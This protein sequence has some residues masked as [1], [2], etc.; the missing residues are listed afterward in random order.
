MNI[1][2]KTLYSDSENLFLTKASF[3]Q[4]KVQ[5]KCYSNVAKFK[6]Y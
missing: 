2:N 5:I 6:F 4:I 3:N 1:R